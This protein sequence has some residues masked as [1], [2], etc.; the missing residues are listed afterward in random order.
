MGE[1]SA[2]EDRP[3]QIADTL[4]YT[5]MDSGFFGAFALS[6]QIHFHLYFEVLAVQAGEYVVEFP[7]HEPICLQDDA[8]C[9]IPPG[10][11]HRTRAL[12]SMP[13]KLALRCSY[14]QTATAQTQ[15]KLYPAFAAMFSGINVPFMLHSTLLRDLLVQIRAELSAPQVGVDSMV[16]LHIAQFWLQLLRQCCTDK[17]LQLRMES[18]AV[19]SDNSR[20][21][22]TERFFG[23]RFSQ[24]VTRQDLAAVLGLSVRQT[25][26]V[27]QEMY[28]TG[29]HQ[30]LLAVRMENAAWLLVNTQLS[31]QTIA[32]RVGYDSGNGF[33]AAF[34]RYFGAA[35]LAYR[36]GKIDVE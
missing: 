5:A 10:C 29:F 34:K 28:G 33:D 27:L 13:Q 6:P 11:S 14:K 22:K 3:V 8:L 24:P 21:I 32:H 20:Y 36:K 31:L 35:A 18:C 9:L 25:G 4:F 26:R 1:I 17:S 15:E 12:S 2:F 19:D 23:E 30:K 7:A 16:S